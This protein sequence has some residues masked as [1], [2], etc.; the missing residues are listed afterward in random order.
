MS[1]QRSKSGFTL[2]ELLIVVAIIAVL[3]AIAVP[4][5][6]EAQTR[7]KTA[8][9]KNDLRVQA[10]ALDSYAIDWNCYTRD[11]DS[12]LDAANSLPSDKAANGAIQL[13][14]PVAYMSSLLA[15]PFAQGVAVSGLGV[16]GVAVG[17]RIASGSWSYDNDPS[18]DPQDAAATFK[19]K[20]AVR[21]YCTFS[22]GPDKARCRNSYKCF[23]WKPVGASDIGSYTQPPFYEDYDPTNG[24][25]SGGDI[26]R[27]G[28]QYMAGDWDRNAMNRGPS[29]PISN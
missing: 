14:T 23:P 22:P 5:F 17:Y 10:T 24:T 16:G 15:D 19:A 6:L 1:Y 29:G 21:A 20:G 13:T 26:Y 7:S 11:S 9:V 2:I 4:N 28:G 12:S 25:L 27:F 8:R 18:K 3:A